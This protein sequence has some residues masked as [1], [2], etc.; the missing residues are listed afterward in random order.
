MMICFMMSSFFDTLIGIVDPGQLNP[1]VFCDSPLA[2]RLEPRGGRGTRKCLRCVM[3]IY[4]S[5]YLPTHRVNPLLNVTLRR[6]LKSETSSGCCD[7]VWSLGV[8]V[9]QGL[10]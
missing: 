10:N 3:V 6:Q 9:Y 7:P 5:Y 2:S 8:G 4:F 1:P